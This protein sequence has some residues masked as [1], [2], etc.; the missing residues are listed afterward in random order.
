MKV[1]ILATFLSLSS[2]ATAMK[3]D[4]T[5][6]EID[7]LTASTIISKYPTQEALIKALGEP[8]KSVT[9][10][11]PEKWQYNDEAGLQRLTIAFNSQKQVESVIWVPTQHD[12][13]S[14]L[15]N[16]LNSSEGKEIKLIKKAQIS[17]PHDLNTQSTYSDNRHISI[18][19]NDS[20]KRIEAIA[21][22]SDARMPAKTEK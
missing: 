21:W 15:E 5:K 6:R 18:L 19:H 11:A 17:P 16:I 14:K 1:V 10:R 4:S 9:D 7:Y 13:E 8:S 20:K 22:F 12:S 2:C 3:S